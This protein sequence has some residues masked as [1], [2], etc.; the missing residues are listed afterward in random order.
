MAVPQQQHIMT[1]RDKHSVIE[2]AKRLDAVIHLQQ[3]A[4]DT[5]FPE[6]IRKE[7]NRALNAGGYLYNP[8]MIGSFWNW[9]F[10]KKNKKIRTNKSPIKKNALLIKI[11]SASRRKSPSK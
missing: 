9:T 4:A 1:H 7:A 8:G 3:I 10:G 5:R 2:T 6:I 11:N